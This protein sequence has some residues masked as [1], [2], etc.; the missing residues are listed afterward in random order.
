MAV[1]AKFSSAHSQPSPPLPKR[2]AASTFYEQNID[3]VML[4]VY[5]ESDDEGEDY[6]EAIDAIAN[7][8][9]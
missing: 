5:S 1:N 6:G 8:L 4:D 7:E 3:A 9:A 2:W